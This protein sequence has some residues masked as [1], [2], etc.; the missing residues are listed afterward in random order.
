MTQTTKGK[1]MIPI[2]KPSLGLDEADAAREAIVSGWITQGPQVAAFEE[3]F[4]DS[5]GARYACAV[6]NCTTALH[7][8]LHALGVGPGD[9]VI[10]VSHSFIATA[11]AI[12]HCGATPVFV[13]IN[14][15]TYN[16]DPKLLEAAITVRTKAILPVHQIGLPVALDSVLEIANKRGIPV[17]E[18]AACAIGSELFCNGRWEPIGSP[19]GLVA[20]FSFHPRKV[21]TT[22]E[23][24]MLTTNDPDLDRQFRLLRQHGMSLSDTQRHHAKAVVFEEYVRLG[25]N[26]RMSDIQASVGRVQLRRLPQMIERRRR[27]ALRYDLALADIPGLETPWIPPGIRFNYQSYAVRITEAFPMTRNALMQHLLDSGISTRRGI[28]NAHQEPAYSEFAT[29]GLA[30]SEAARDCVI[31][32]PMYDSLTNEQQDQVI[33]EV[34]AASQSKCLMGVSV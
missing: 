16:M 18:D 22:G 31:L 20:C 1:K 29:R 6:S 34:T 12:R 28:M 33:L 24:G 8:A 11:N 26:Y 30:E 19:H 21:I 2:S 15:R 17:I 10:T 5:V 13:D 3:E 25:F 7:L 27:L 14:P 4:A 23:G 32:L 9:E